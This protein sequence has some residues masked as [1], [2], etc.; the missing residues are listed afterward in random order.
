MTNTSTDGRQPSFVSNIFS[1]APRRS[2][3][4]EES[5]IQDRFQQTEIA[6]L[7]VRIAALQQMNDLLAAQ[8]SEIRRE[9]EDLREQR[10]YWRAA[11]SNADRI[12]PAPELSPSQAMMSGTR[13]GF[14][15]R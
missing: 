11:A 7:E 10:D 2:M 3:K 9:R 12:S 6:T 14:W 1:D 15:R 13:K 8:L 4:R 5:S